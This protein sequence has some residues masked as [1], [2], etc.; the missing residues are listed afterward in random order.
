VSDIKYFPSVSTTYMGPTNNRGSKIKV[1]CYNF[2][3]IKF[4]DFDHAAIYPHETAVYSFFR[5]LEKEKPELS[6]FK[7]M[8]RTETAK[9][10][11]YLINWDFKQ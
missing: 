11:I 7:I 1:S 8:S 5:L 9:E 10:K 2:N 3:I 4:F 6:K